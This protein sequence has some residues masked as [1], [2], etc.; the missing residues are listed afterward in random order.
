LLCRFDI[1]DFWLCYSLCSGDPLAYV[2][3]AI[4]EL[5][6]AR[7]TAS[8]K[9]DNVLI[10]QRQVLQVHNYAATTRFRADHCFQL[11][12]VFSTH[13]T[14]QLKDYLAIRYPCDPQHGKFFFREIA[15]STDWQSRRQT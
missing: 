5:D 14:T 3:W 10:Y 6:A 8:K 12:Y 2:W 9:T 4:L 15:A 11:G 7:F 1:A 13:S